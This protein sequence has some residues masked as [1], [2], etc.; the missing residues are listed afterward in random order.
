M[1]TLRLKNDTRGRVLE[2]GYY[3]CHHTRNVDG[4]G[5]SKYARWLWASYVRTYHRSYA[6]LTLNGQRK[7]HNKILH[8][9]LAS[10]S[11][12]EYFAFRADTPVRALTWHDDQAM[13]YR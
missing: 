6:C 4:Y 7:R 2:N 10:T 1:S 8:L 5:M 13:T 9:F 11:G 12:D 3:E